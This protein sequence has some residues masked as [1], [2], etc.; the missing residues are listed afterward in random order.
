MAH[1]VALLHCCEVASVL[2]YV[3]WLVGIESHCPPVYEG[4]ESN[5]TL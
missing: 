2:V 1:F 3:V 5:M 4:L